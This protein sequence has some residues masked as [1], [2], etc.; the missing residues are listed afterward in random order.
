[1]VQAMQSYPVQKR[2]FLHWL[3]PLQF[4]EAKLA[5]QLLYVDQSL[6]AQILILTAVKASES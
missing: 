2:L 6:M 5:Q 1:M 3:F 4:D